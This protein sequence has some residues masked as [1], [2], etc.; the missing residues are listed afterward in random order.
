MLQ[1]SGIQHFMYCPRQWALIHVEGQWNDNHLTSEGELL[2]KRCDDPYARDNNGRDIVIL[3]S[4]RLSS[5]TLGLSGAADIVEIIPH[6]GA[7]R[8]KRALL[9]SR[10]FEV[11]PIEYKRGVRKTS[12]CDR[13]Q[14]A[15][16]SMI[17]E[18]M[19]G[20]DISRG[21]IF[22]WE[23][24]HRE[25]FDIDEVLRE[26]VKSLSSQMHRLTE[27]SSTPEAKKNK[28]CRSCSLLEL[29]QPQLRNMKASRYIKETLNEE[30]T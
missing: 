17:L 29:C 14:V 30:T 5:K 12:D 6:E 8:G 16:Q 20:V 11:L 2:H 27:T 13:V 3:R 22:Y 19:L 1:L 4:L 24:R 9:K 28:G 25:Y 10:K 18:E 23:E 15:A 21:A 7:P 26:K